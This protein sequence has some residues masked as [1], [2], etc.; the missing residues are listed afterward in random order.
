M[1]HVEKGPVIASTL[2]S[3]DRPRGHGLE[4]RNGGCLLADSQSHSRTLK[5][6]LGLSLYL[7]EGECPQSPIHPAPAGLG[8]QTWGC[9]QIKELLVTLGVGTDVCV[10][11][12]P[13]LSL[14]TCQGADKHPIRLPPL[15]A[16]LW[17]RL[18]PKDG[19]YS[20]RR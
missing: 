12:C 11:P 2:S 3:R 15:A 10:C 13:P 19:L 1:P 20:E 8:S 18:Q 4:P 14:V 17:P 6:S 9:S 16:Q 5:D 7:L